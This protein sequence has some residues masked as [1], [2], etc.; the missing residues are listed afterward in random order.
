M[1]LNLK[2][3]INSLGYGIVGVNVLRALDAQGVWIAHF[4]IGQS[5]P[6][7]LEDYQC[8]VKTDNNQRLFDW[9]APCLK[10][11]HQF[12]MAERI[13]KCELFG[14]PIFELDKF[15]DHELHHLNYCD[16]IITCSEWAQKVVLQHLP[17]KPVH[18]VPFGVNRL[19]FNEQANTQS[20]KCIFFNCG[21]WEIRKGHDFLK[22]IF[23]ETFADTKDV[24]LWMM[25][26]N[27]FFSEQETAEWEQLYTHPKIRLIHRVRTQAELAGIMSQVT[28]GVFPSRAEGWNLELLEM[29]SCGKYVIA[30]NYSGHTQFCDDKNT[31]LIDI[32]ETEPAYDGKWFN[33]AGNWACINDVEKKSLGDKLLGVYNVWKSNVNMPLNL[34]G[35]ET[36]KAFTWKNTAKKLI[37]ILWR[38]Q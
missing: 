4:P 33:G 37:E 1:N 13:G 31:W 25:C 17:D 21:K 2:C 23:L 18:V 34:Y 24:E 3:P 29:L 22:E 9:H 10:I 11:W 35:I 20:K 38:Q 27:P 7:T 8:V 5:S 36:A 6:E 14:L 12:D 26:D 16:E 32:T 28:C 15:A 19:I 30:T